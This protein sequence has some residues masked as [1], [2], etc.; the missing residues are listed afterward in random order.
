M[1]AHVLHIRPWEIGDLR[2]PDFRQ[3]VAW[4]EEYNRTDGG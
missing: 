3:L 4:L 1:F 2:V